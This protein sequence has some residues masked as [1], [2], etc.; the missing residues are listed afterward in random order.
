MRPS[1]NS[2]L[3]WG[4]LGGGGGDVDEKSKQTLAN[5]G[6]ETGWWASEKEATL[7]HV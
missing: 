5:E 2:G 3:C 6:Q 1:C 7:Q 4:A